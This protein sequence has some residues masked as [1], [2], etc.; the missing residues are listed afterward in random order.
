VQLPPE[1]VDIDLL[2]DATRREARGGWFRNSC[3]FN[4]VW[5]FIRLEYHRCYHFLLKKE[6]IRM[7]RLCNLSI[8][9]LYSDTD[10]SVITLPMFFP[11]PYASI[12][13]NV[14]TYAIIMQNK[15]NSQH[16]QCLVY[17]V[18][19]VMIHIFVYSMSVLPRY[20]SKLSCLLYPDANIVW[21]PF[22]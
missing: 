6:T 8:V 13:R 16:M 2:H 18:S 20:D 14:K 7:S 19:E 1:G 21:N 9:L 11:S 15:F 17:Q 10:T 4:F 22:V 3:N 5:E 12:K